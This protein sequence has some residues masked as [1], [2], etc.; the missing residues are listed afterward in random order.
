MNSIL[1]GLSFLTVYVSVLCTDLF[2][3]PWFGHNKLFEYER[4]NSRLD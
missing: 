4:L 3:F 1:Y 2:F